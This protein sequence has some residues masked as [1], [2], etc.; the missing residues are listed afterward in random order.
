MTDRVK[1]IVENQVRRV[2]LEA[3]KTYDPNHPAN[4]VNLVY[5]KN[6]RYGDDFSKNG[7]NFPVK[8]GNK[9]YYVSRSSSVSLFAYAQDRNGNWYVLA[10]KRGQGHNK[11]L[12]NVVRGYVDLAPEGKPQETLEQAACRE[13]FEENGVKINPSKLVMIR[14]NSAGSTINTSFYTVIDDRTVEQMPTSTK[15]AEKG[16]VLE[17]RWIPL[18]EIDKY[19]FAFNDDAKIKGVANMAIGNDQDMESNLLAQLRQKI[20]DNQEAQQ[21]LNQLIIYLRKTI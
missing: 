10:N 15:N 2:L 3:S 21:L 18:A 12:F 13:A 9:T 6:T 5:D 1:T 20:G 11:G 7:G 19:S 4:K 14:V 17:S 16:E 8:R